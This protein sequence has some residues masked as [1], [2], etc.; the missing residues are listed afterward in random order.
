MGGEGKVQKRG[1]TVEQGEGSA[2][3]GRLVAD[4]EAAIGKEDD[5]AVAGSELVEVVPKG[6]GPARRPHDGV[7]LARAVV[8]GR[9]A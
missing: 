1:G 2:L 4:L 3:V 8:Q 5:E 9:G 6:G 7:P